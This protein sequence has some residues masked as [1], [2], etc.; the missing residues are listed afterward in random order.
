V[1]FADY[2]NRNGRQIQS[3]AER[4]EESA[5]K[6]SRALD[7]VL[8]NMSKSLSSLITANAA[9]NLERESSQDE[10]SQATAYDEFF[11]N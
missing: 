3:V 9:A 11:K 10:A 7:R 5:N 6:E 1:V 4:S 8:E 2:S